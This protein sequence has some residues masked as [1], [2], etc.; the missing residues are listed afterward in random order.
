MFTDQQVR[1][2]RNLHQPRLY[3]TWFGL[4]VGYFRKIGV[5]R[6]KLRRDWTWKRETLWRWGGNFSN[7]G[8]NSWCRNWSSNFEGILAGFESILSLD[9]DASV[10]SLST[11]V[12][13]STY[14]VVVTIPVILAIRLHS[15]DVG[16]QL[17]HTYYLGNWLHHLDY[18]EYRWM[19]KGHILP[20]YLT[21]LDNWRF[22]NALDH[23]SMRRRQFPVLHFRHISR[24]CA[25]LY[26]LAVS[27]RFS[28]AQPCWHSASAK[29]W[30]RYGSATEQQRS[31]VEFEFP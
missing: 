5:G 27:H 13:W 2:F 26:S 3:R 21:H 31:A 29:K 19:T 6:R 1:Y 23:T 10:P 16:V 24:S 18:G 20:I 25:S 28:Q 9:F 22:Q 17:W 14:P 11:V 12:Q 30:R 8:Q 7:C 15:E 4:C